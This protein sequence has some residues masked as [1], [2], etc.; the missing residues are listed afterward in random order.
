VKYNPFH[1][2]DWNATILP[3]LNEN[4]GR[5]KRLLE[6]G[7]ASDH[8]PGGS[9]SISPLTGDLD[10]GNNSALNLKS[11]MGVVNVKGFGAK[12]DGVT[13]DTEAIQNAINN[14]NGKVV[15]FPAGTY[16]ISNTLTIP[17]AISLLGANK[18]ETIIKNVNTSGAD[19]IKMGE[20]GS[21]SDHC[22][23]ENL[24]IQGNE[25][26]G[27]G[28]IF[29]GSFALIINNRFIENGGAGMVANSAWT[30]NIVFNEFYGNY[31][32]GLILN[33][34]SN[35]I[36][37]LG[38]EI[39]HNAQYGIEIYGCSNS[40]IIGN[41]IE[42]NGYCGIVMEGTA[43][44]A[45]RSMIIR[46]N[47]FELNCKD[48]GT[49]YD[50]EIRVDRAGNEISRLE[51]VGNYFDGGG[52]RGIDIYAINSAYIANNA[53]VCTLGWEGYNVF[54]ERQEVDYDASVNNAFKSSFVNYNGNDG[55]TIEGRQVGFKLIR[56]TSGNTYEIFSVK[57]PGNVD[58][59][60]G[61]L[62]G[63]FV[64]S[65]I[66]SADA[67][68]NSIFIDSSDNVLKFKDNGGA[69]HSLY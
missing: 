53:A 59:G 46:G 11:A 13:D 44:Q 49:P 26:S 32:S 30:N 8:Q 22:R 38:N 41:G 45:M 58:R 42:Q 6:K 54:T 56:K 37:V 57:T 1:L 47:Y 48:A 14:S 10:F 9:D 28:L 25:S 2:L 39:H 34:H 31:G 24:T 52:S 4:F 5:L 33:A 36:V 68:N 7:H 60:E 20:S 40:R 19:A 65:A 50:A 55:F 51:I 61:F 27:N 64:L 43:E 29:E 17:S 3:L 67:P 16:I 69:I 63:A 12:G 18:H 23:I 21:R 66:S 35:N 15:F 62:K